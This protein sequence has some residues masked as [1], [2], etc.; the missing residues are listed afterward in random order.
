ME[1]QIIQVPVEGTLLKELNLEC[2]KQRKSRAEIVR[3]ACR[4]Y[5]KRRM[6][7]ELERIYIKGYTE[8]PE[9]PDFA[10]S[11]EKMLGDVLSE[12]SW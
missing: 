2:K 4:S 8:I 9:S 3:T 7:E 5:L 6:E 12:E 11:Q 10:I 1:K